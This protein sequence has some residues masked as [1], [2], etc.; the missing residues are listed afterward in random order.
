[1]STQK[2]VTKVTTLGLKRLKEAGEK[3]ASLTAYDAAFATVL[4]NAGVDFILVGDSVGMVVQGRE[5]TIPVTI[6]EMIYHTQLVARGTQRAMVM[7]D[8]PFM[9]YSSA[10]DCL[11]NA[12]R[13]MKEGGAEIVKLEWGALEIPMV[14]RLTD[15]G[16]PV[17]AHLGLT[18]QAIHKYGAYR[19]QG[20]EDDTAQ[21]MIDDA[22]ALEA[23]GADVLLLECVPTGLAAQ[24]RNNAQVPVI[25]I[26]A[27]P[28]VDGQILVL[29]DI[30]DIWPGKRTRFSK[31]YMAQAGSIQ[32]AIET[33]VRE[34]KEVSFPT[35]EYSFE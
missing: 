14:S 31:N 2:D 18:P 12:A 29:Y 35:A 10:H 3:I 13:L 33:Y 15:C 34:V 21:K 30:L 27:G 32:G 25:G 24:I 20:R 5:T 22:L 8:M 7:A 19:V 9:S 6:E 26:G 4:D 17:C 11:H 28:E 1:M 16:I 23:A